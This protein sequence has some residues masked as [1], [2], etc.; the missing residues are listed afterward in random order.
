MAPKKK[1]Y[2]ELAAL[3]GLIR[4]KGTSY[5]KL[6]IEVGMSTNSLNGKVNGLYAMT[7]SEMEKI[8]ELLD[9]DPKDIAKYFLPTYCKTY[10]RTA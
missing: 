4:E 1:R 3:K 5:R 10:Q 7:C 8:A 2:P 6:A 9:I